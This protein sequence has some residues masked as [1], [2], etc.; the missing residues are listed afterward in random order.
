MSIQRAVRCIAAFGSSLVLASAPLAA[1]GARLFK[2]GP[3]QISADGRWVWA[4]N[5]DNDSV[6][7]LDAAAGTLVEFALGDGPHSPRGISLREDG[8]EVWVA[9]H[10]GDHLH[11]LAGA[12]GAEV[13][14]IEL[15]WGSGPHSVALSRDGARALATLHRAAALA[16]VDA[17]ARKVARLLA[18]VHWSPAGIAW[19]EDG[20]SA[21]VTHLFAPG[22]HPLLTRVDF[23]G[24]EPEVKTSMQLFAADPRASSRLA[25][26]YDIAEGGYLTTRG[27]PAQIPSASGRRELWLPIQYNNITED[28]YSPDS[29]VQSVIRRLDLT[30]RKLLNG[31]NEKV[32]FSAVHVHDGNNY[33]GPGWD[34]RVSGPIDVGFSADGREVYLLHELSNDLLVFA[35]N[36]AATRPAGAAPLAEIAAGDRPLGLAVSPAAERA[37]VLNSLSRDISV[38][39]L[40]A[41]AEVARIA[42]TP[43][44]GE[45]EPA[46]VLR[47]ARIFHSSAD[48]R[49]SSNQ[50]VACGSCHI[51]AEHDGRTWAFHRLPGPHGP[52]E[53][54]SLLG[55]RSTFAPFDAA[56]QRG[57]LHLSGDRDEVQDFEHTFQGVNMGGE[58]F[59]GAAAQPELG[60]PNAGLSAELD[61]L[62]AYVMSLE[63][64]ARSPFRAPGGALSEAAQRGAAFFLGLDRARKSA[65]AGCARCHVPETGF[66]DFKF[67][68]VGQQRSASEE[69]LSALG[70]RVNTQT[71]VGLWATPH[72]GGASKFTGGFTVRAQMHE[73][74]LDFAARAR[75]ATPHGTPDGLTWRQLDDLAEFVLSIDGDLDAAEARAARDA[76]P[77][78]IERVA[79]TSLSRLEVWFNETI[80]RASVENTANWRLSRVGGGPVAIS[81]VA[82]D[83]RWGDRIGIEAALSSNAEYELAAAAG[84]VDAAAAASGGTANAL[85]PSD[86]RNLRRFQ[87]GDTVTVTLG[88]GPGAQIACAVHDAAMV[89][90]NLSTWSHDSVWIFPVNG[91]PGF[92][93]GLVRFAWRDAFAAA[94]GVASSSDIVEARITL[95]A[96]FGEAARIEA[97]RVYKAWSDASSGGDWNQNAA[98]AP[99]W[100]SASHPNGRWTSAGAGS[101]GGNGD[102][103]SDYGAAFDLAQRVDASVDAPS[104][105]G[106]VV[107][108]GALITDAYRFW[109]DNPDLDRGHAL[110]LAAGS[111][112]ELKFERWESGLRDLG[113]E[114]T[115]T[116][117]LPSAE[118]SFRRGD[119]NGDGG[120]DVS[121]AVRVLVYNFAG[122]AEPP[123]LAACD[124]SGDGQVAGSV[125]DALAML[126]FAFGGGPPLPEPFPDCGAGSLASDEAL[127]C[128]SG[129]GP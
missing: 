72:F 11:V 88:A 7:R 78:R 110:R 89:G 22:E 62:A 37:Y 13:A 81:N 111:R 87:I 59:L 108:A 18:P 77:P 36:T 123:C 33:I 104:V 120:F 92:N 19:T 80:E 103:R 63:P 66:V 58:G 34:A 9:C 47:G 71:L 60:A 54:P 79:P 101:L 118:T 65:D 85:D 4:A 17:A 74:L 117:R 121:D 119:C 2:S 6:S 86:A 43:A 32:I 122:G 75:S 115:I 42:A 114:L 124:A 84:I 20:L 51:N 50:K 94:T 83:S 49:I 21:W 57:Q 25:A 44:S 69:E 93:S 46:T 45:A 26:P 14:R 64:L 126:H 28:V 73:V 31:V 112:S 41:R 24:A 70:W 30:T 1:A 16:V 38:I 107:F 106:E 76:A 113:P 116:Y 67:H 96:E 102:R 48:P 61:D 68:D 23:A 99:T 39:D 129:C 97:R 91:G 35:H 109:F 98:G 95:H 15:P 127:G 29:T 52:R 5:A 55:L 128:E 82:W 100:Q 40:A 53:V 27:H 90:P 3:I 56:L 125:T 10:D 105:N 8:S 12:D